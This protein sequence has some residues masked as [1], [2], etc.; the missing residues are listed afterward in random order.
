MAK[1]VLEESEVFLELPADSVAFVKVEDVAIKEVD[2]SKGPWT[3]IEFKFKILDVI[4]VGDGSPREKYASVAGSHIWGSTAFR[5]TDNPE[6]KLRQWAEALLNMEL[7][8]GFELD[9]DFLI[10]RQCRAVTSTYQKRTINPRTG[11]PNTGQQ[12]AYLLPQ[13]EKAD[14]PTKLNPTPVEASVT[15]PAQAPAPGQ[16]A[17]WWG[18]QNDN[19]QMPF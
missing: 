7:A 14:S 12:V 13:Y 10:G 15:I 9:T 16:V 5:L 1:I 19:S 3:K 6:N 18:D 8:P 17:G 11:L 4:L 2:G